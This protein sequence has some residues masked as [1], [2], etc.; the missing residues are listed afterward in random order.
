MC[1]KEVWKLERYGEVSRKTR[2]TDIKVGIKIDGSGQYNINTGIGFFDH[3][4]SGFARHG[5]FDLDVSVNGDLEVDGHHTVEDTGIVL[6]QAFNEAL[7][8]KRRIRR[9]GDCILPMDDALVLAGVDVS[10]RHFFEFDLPM[11]AAMVG[12]FDTELVKEFFY[13]FADAAKINL[14]IKKINGRNAHHI[15]EA[16]FKA[17][18]RA[19]DAA[20]SIDERNKDVPSTKGLL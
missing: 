1:R 8:D 9:F 19:L 6:G 3:M 16:T 12:Q 14:H 10:G 7:G 20:T 4:L 11:E 2:E 18:A 17:V 13:A 15:I 5:F